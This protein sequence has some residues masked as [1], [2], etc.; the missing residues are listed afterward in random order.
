MNRI[1]FTPEN[2]KTRREALGMSQNELSRRSGV[3]VS[4]ICSYESGDKKPGLK[5]MLK[6]GEAL[7]I[8]FEANWKINE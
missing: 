8:I 6:L 3:S 2:L 5:A 7:N 4:A 1:S